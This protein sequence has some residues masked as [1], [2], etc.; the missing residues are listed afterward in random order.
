MI[1]LLF[2]KI[3]LLKQIYEEDFYA[4]KFFL[5]LGIKFPQKA[6]KLTK[7][8]LKS[9]IVSKQTPSSKNKLLHSRMKNPP[10]N[11]KKEP[12]VESLKQ[13]KRATWLP[14]K[15]FIIATRK[16]MRKETS[17]AGWIKGLK[18]P[19][20][21]KTKGSSALLLFSS[22]VQRE[23]NSLPYALWALICYKEKKKKKSG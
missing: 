9:E 19:G 16:K 2:N 17:S 13:T 12:Q 7:L 20:V 21:F 23:K 18:N 6:L 11:K 3:Y 4:R 14:V 1:F 10:S 15:R 22:Y 5:T 8:H